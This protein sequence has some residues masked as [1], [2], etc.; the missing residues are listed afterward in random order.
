MTE[1]MNIII[2]WGHPYVGASFSHYGCWGETFVTYQ[3]Y[4]SL[5]S[6]FQLILIFSFSR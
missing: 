5:S 4:F 1:K 3:P 2:M 6:C